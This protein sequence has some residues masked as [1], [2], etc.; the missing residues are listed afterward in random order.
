[1]NRRKKKLI[2]KY[3]I[4]REFKITGSITICTFDRLITNNKKGTYIIVKWIN[5]SK[6]TKYSNYSLKRILTHIN[7]KTWK[8][9]PLKQQNKTL[10]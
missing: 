6:K 2:E 4:G 5:R 9:I 10:Q 3:I 1:M 8:L 7:N